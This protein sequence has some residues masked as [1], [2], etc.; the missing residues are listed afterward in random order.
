[1]GYYTDLLKKIETV[2]AQ[3]FNPYTETYGARIGQLEAVSPTNDTNISPEID[4]SLNTPKIA[5]NTGIGYSQPT[6]PPTMQPYQ[7]S[8]VSEMLKQ[9]GQPDYL[10]QI[11]PEDLIDEQTI[12][13]VYNAIKE[14]PNLGIDPGRWIETTNVGLEE[15]KQRMHDP[16]TNSIKNKRVPVEDKTYRFEKSYNR[17]K[18]GDDK[19][20][21]LRFDEKTGEN[22]SYKTK[23]EYDQAIIDY[24]E[25][26][27]KKGTK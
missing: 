7:R 5:Q 16:S 14:N 15:G 21:Y 10:E 9:A 22:I 11:R 26:Q 17:H 1:M 18:K 24:R 20:V 4:N 23:E 13:T 25:R 27:E 3:G 2:D 12:S 8:E 19:N 6:D